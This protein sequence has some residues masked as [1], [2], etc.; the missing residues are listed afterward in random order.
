MCS[1]IILEEGLPTLRGNIIYLKNNITHTMYRCTF[2]SD[3]LVRLW[4]TDIVDCDGLS[5]NKLELQTKYFFS[6]HLFL[7]T[8]MIW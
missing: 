3:A 2:D 5:G 7:N 1:I 8:R 6:F 4:H